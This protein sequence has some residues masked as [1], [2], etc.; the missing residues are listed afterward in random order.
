MKK[1][2]AKILAIVLGSISI[3]STNPRITKESSAEKITQ[4]IIL[5]VEEL[6]FYEN[7]LDDKEKSREKNEWIMPPYG[8][9]PKNSDEWSKEK[10]LQYFNFSKDK[11][12]NRRILRELSPANFWLV[13]DKLRYDKIIGLMGRNCG[14]HAKGDNMAEALGKMENN[15]N[16]VAKKL[17]EDGYNGNAKTL[18]TL[19]GVETGG[20]GSTISCSGRGIGIAQVSDFFREGNL[21]D[22]NQNLYIGGKFLSYL[23]DVF[24]EEEI[25][26]LAYNNG[27]QRV[28][29]IIKRVSAKNG[30]N[31][32]EITHG[33]IIKAGYKNERFNG[34]YV[35]KFNEVY[36][37][38]DKNF[39]YDPETNTLRYRNREA[40]VESKKSLF[41]A[42]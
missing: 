22:I 25:A 41:T 9:T 29:G 36:E 23:T 2:L 13:Y 15:V 31:A 18:M 28:K 12:H 10:I 1:N 38:I 42:D 32:D 34:N 19:V 5:P 35:K 20:I 4:E 17:T 11:Y 24:Q 26:L 7:S 21:L 30:K 3:I 27:P 37:I 33:E 14:E 16:V 8:I 40:F 6:D 39:I